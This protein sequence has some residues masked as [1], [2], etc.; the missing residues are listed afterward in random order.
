[1]LSATSVCCLLSSQYLISLL[2]SYNVLKPVVTTQQHLS[3]VFSDD[4]CS[5]LYFTVD[6]K[7]YAFGIIS[8]Y[9]NP[10]LSSLLRQ[11]LK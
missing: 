9:L 6:Y 3:T 10:E 2:L 7:L 4:A 1:M 8:D 5:D 11:H